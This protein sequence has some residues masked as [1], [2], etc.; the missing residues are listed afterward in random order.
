M[1]RNILAVIV[2]YVT[3][4]AI[5]FLALTIAFLAMGTD[6]AF[7]QGSFQVSPMWLV[8][9]YIISLLAALAGGWVTATI[10]PRRNAVLA[11]VVLVVILGILSAVPALSAAETPDVR[12]GDLSNME[13][14]MNARQPPWVALSIP[15]IG[16]VGAW[17]G[18]QRRL[19]AGL[20]KGSV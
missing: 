8:V 13:A 10:A 18:G 16:A 15:I 4:F 2:G 19:K 7:Q 11:L 14:M 3:M 9:M 17:L 6:L 12:S 1:G 20:G 5:V